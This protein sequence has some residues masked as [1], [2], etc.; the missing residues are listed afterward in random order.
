MSTLMAGVWLFARQVNNYSVVD[1]AWSFFFPLQAAIFALFGAALLKSQAF[2]SG[3]SRCK[4]P[5]FIPE[6]KNPQFVRIVGFSKAD[7]RLF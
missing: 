3:N 6:T 7:R 5:Q 1:A 2:A 4:S